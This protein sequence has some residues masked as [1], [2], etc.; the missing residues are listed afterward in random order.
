[1]SGRRRGLAGALAALALLATISFASAASQ[2]L[3]GATMTSTAVGHPCAGPAAATATNGT[4]MTF[5]AVSITVPAGCAGRTVL[6][7]LLNGTTPVGSGSAAAA[8]SGATVVSLP[9]Y[10]ALSSLTVQATVGGWNLPTTWSFTPP[11]IWC[12][13]VSG[14]SPGATCTA[15]VTRFTGI[16]ESGSLVAD[17]YDVVVETTSALALRWQVTF[18]LP[19]PFYGT[20]PTALGN[21][22][23]DDYSDVARYWDTNDATREG[24]CTA[25]QLKVRGVNSNNSGSNFRDVTSGAPRQFSLV[26]NRTEAAYRDV[27]SGGCA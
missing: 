7:T 8:A 4:T 25:G 22:D 12:T 14:G 16:K 1:M 5:S 26:L 11:H 21:S 23:L 24:Q 10:T 2:P 27:L 6:L 18:N 17:Y 9:T 19:H 3:A 20:V 15:T 13:V